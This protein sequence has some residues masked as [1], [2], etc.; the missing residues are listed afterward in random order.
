MKFEDR[1][2][3]FLRKR[4]A[5][6]QAA[7]WVLCAAKLGIPMDAAVREYRYQYASMMYFLENRLYDN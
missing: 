4:Q 7:G 1:R 3:F 6:E 5:L 2:D